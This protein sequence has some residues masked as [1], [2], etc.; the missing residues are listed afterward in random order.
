MGDIND[1]V[2]NIAK[3]EL[4][5]AQ[6]DFEDVLQSKLADRLDQQR[7]YVASQTFSPTE[8][9]EPELAELD[10][11]DGLLDELETDDNDDYA[12]EYDYADEDED[13]SYEEPD[14]D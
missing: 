9:E 11:I 3:G 13:T 12:G 7:T 14:E 2:V 6:T 5:A 10:E 8:D 1:M 4:A